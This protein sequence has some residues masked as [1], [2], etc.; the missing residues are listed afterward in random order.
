M[1]IK[2]IQVGSTNSK[3]LGLLLDDYFDRLKHYV[4]FEVVTIPELKQVQKLSHDQVKAKE[5]ELILDK[6]GKSEMILLDENGTEYSSRS[7]SGFI[8]K[9]QLS[10]S[11]EI[12]FVIGGAFGFDEKAYAHAKDKIALSKMTF[13]HQMVRLIFAEQLYRAFTILKGEKYHHD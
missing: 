1:K 11:K 13:S 2:L 7:F 6:A 5:W 12:C 9:K 3:P 8:Q 10:G 4:K